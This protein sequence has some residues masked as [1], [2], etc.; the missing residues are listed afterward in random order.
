MCH[1]S[2]RVTTGGGFPGQCAGEL[3]E[4]DVVVRLIMDNAARWALLVEEK[5]W[6]AEI[7]G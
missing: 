3:M 5:V 2:Y 7:E 6:L 4:V 1:W